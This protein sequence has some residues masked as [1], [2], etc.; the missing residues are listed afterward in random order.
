MPEATEQAKDCF[1]TVLEHGP[2]I[3]IDHYLVY[4]TRAPFRIRITYSTSLTSTLALI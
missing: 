3:E 1:E 2:K 4:T